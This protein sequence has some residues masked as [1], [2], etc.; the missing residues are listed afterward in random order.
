MWEARNISVLK[1]VLAQE[2]VSQ[3]AQSRST[4]DGHFRSVPCFG[5]EPI[6][7]PLVVFV[8]VM[9]YWKCLCYFWWFDF[10]LT[11]YQNKS[12]LEQYVT[13][14]TTVSLCNAN[15][16]EVID[17]CKFLTSLPKNILFIKGEP[18]VLMQSEELCLA[19][20]WARYFLPLIR[21]KDY[22]LVQINEGF[23]QVLPLI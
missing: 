14:L 20:L 12:Y 18:S 19:E 15:M 11:F 13:I 10:I 3:H 23:L 4:D 2:R 16:C 8:T 9:R 5:Q 17:N 6:H 21:L 1:G 7:C 22:L